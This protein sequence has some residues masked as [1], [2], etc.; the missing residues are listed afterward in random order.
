MAQQRDSLRLSSLRIRRYRSILEEEIDLGPLNVLI[1]P[2]ASGKSNV[3][4]ALKFMAEGVSERDFAGPVHGR[5]GIVHLG[6]KGEAAREVEVSA[7]FSEGEARFEWTVALSRKGFDFEVRED[8]DRVAPGRAPERLLKMNA[9]RG[10]WRSKDK[11]VEVRDRPTICALPAASA[12]ADFPAREVADVVRGWRFFDPSPMMLRRAAHVAGTQ[13]E[14][15][16]TSGANLAARLHTLRTSAPQTFRRIVQVTRSILGVPESIDTRRSDDGRVYFVQR[17]PGLKYDVHQIGASSGTLRIL[18]LV[19]ALLGEDGS[20][21]VGIEEPENHVHPSALSAFAEHVRKAAERVQV[22]ITTH[23]PIL[24]D[25]LGDP[26]AVC[27]VSRNEDGATKVKRETNPDAVRKALEE[28]G[29]GL[30]EL[31]QTKGFG[32]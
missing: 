3:L 14:G 29:L 17:E 15:L 1:G 24:L 27:V 21:L 25:C 11:A 19:T 16:E 4:D 12:D 28:S 8:L 32:G 9:G 26:A 30:G 23:S 31:H 2:N 10:T 20:T 18:A 6:W 22:L 5:G 13:P 7:S